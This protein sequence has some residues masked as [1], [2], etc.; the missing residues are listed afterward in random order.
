MVFVPTPRFFLTEDLEPGWVLAINSD[1]DPMPEGLLAQFQAMGG[2]IGTVEFEGGTDDCWRFQDVPTDNEYETT[3]LRLEK[4]LRTFETLR[5]E[6]LCLLEGEP[7][8]ERDINTFTKWFV[9]ALKLRDGI[10]DRKEKIAA[11]DWKDYDEMLAARRALYR[12]ANR[13]PDFSWWQDPDLDLLQIEWEEECAKEAD[14]ADVAFAARKTASGFHIGM[15]VQTRV[16]PKGVRTVPVPIGTPGVIIG[17]TDLYWQVSHR[18]PLT[19]CEGT[20]WLPHDEK[21]TLT[22]G[23][24]TEEIER[25]G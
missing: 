8:E 12:A 7:P 16:A 5:G 24:L 17:E 6:R 21:T 18:L 23:Y 2:T 9:G 10:L 4:W 14:F 22:I 19:D 15:P 20:T 1:A 13:H 3:R 11:P 25:I